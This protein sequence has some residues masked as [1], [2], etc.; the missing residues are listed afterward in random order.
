[1]SSL[2]GAVPSTVALC[3]HSGVDT[4]QKTPKPKKRPALSVCEGAAEGMQ[5]SKKD[6]PPPVMSPRA[7]GPK[8]LTTLQRGDTQM[9]ERSLVQ[10]MRVIK[11]RDRQMADLR[12]TTKQLFQESRSLMGA[13]PNSADNAGATGGPT[14]AVAQSGKELHLRDL[15]L[16][17]PRNSVQCSPIIMVRERGVLVKL[18][19]VSGIVLHDTVLLLDFQARGTAAAAA[20]A[21]SSVRHLSAPQ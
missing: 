2:T 11:F 7:K 13:S 18:E 1:M 20:P 14:Q 5:K 12:W 19:K 15:R 21:R 4:P 10:E 9:S 6:R 16:I 3:V 8:S 17:D